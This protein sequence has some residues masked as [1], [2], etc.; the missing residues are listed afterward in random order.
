MQQ[1]ARLQ[2]V[3]LLGLVS[4]ALAQADSLLVLNK[5]GSVAVVDPSAQKVL[6]TIKAGERPH[7]IVAAGANLAVISNYEGGRTLSVVDLKSQKELRRADL[8]PSSRPHGL[9]YSNGRVYFTAEGSSNIGRYD[10]VANRV[11]WTLPTGQS[12]THMILLSRDGAKIFTSNLGSGSVSI[13]EQ[14]GARWNPTHI[15]VGPGAEGFDLSPDEKQIW[16]A[17][18][19]DGTVSIIDVAARKV[20]ATIEIGAQ[21]SNRLKFTPDGKLVLVS[22]FGT[23][24]LILVDT[25]SRKITKRVPIAS[26][27]AGIFISPDGSRAYV[28]ATADNF[29]AV[30]DLRKLAVT[31]RIRTGLG[32]DGMDWIRG[33]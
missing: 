7:E 24:N 10:P 4:L 25:A 9:A 12:G 6:S 22:D 28:A 21:R 3:A 29:V 30:V 19:G 13:Y 23:G 8:S 26:S 32:P 20:A 2:R 5:D 16:A 17:N 33:H 15:T 14:S 11:D 31:A 27:I 18:A 1:L